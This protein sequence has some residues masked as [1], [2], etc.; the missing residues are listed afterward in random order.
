LSRG[1]FDSPNLPR[2]EFDGPNLPRGE[3]DSPNLPRGEF[4]RCNSSRDELSRSHRGNSLV[5]P[6]GFGL[7]KEEC[8]LD[9]DVSLRAVGGRFKESFDIV[10]KHVGNEKACTCEMKPPVSEGTEQLGKL[11]GLSRDLDAGVRA[12][13]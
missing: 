10:R 2:G 4:G 1:E 9:F 3:F 5:Q 13:F 8:E 7:W 11:E 6:Q 12:A